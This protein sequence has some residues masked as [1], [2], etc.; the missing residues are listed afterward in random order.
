MVDF[1]A[2]IHNFFRV[3]FKKLLISFVY[4]WQNKVVAILT[5]VSGVVLLFSLGTIKHMSENRVIG[6][7]N[8]LLHYQSYPKH[9]YS[10]VN[11]MCLLPGKYA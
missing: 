3:L 8:D 7:D 1:G 11:S 6:Y 4:I 10:E 9:A 5:H 2:V